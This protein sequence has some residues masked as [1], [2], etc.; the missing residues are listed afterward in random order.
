MWPAGELYM[1]TLFWFT[2]LQHNFPGSI[3]VCEL[4]CTL[5]KSQNLIPG[6]NKKPLHLTAELRPGSHLLL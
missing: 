5:I 6:T 2:N 4:C 3:N 1:T